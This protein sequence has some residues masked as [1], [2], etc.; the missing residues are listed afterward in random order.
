MG[1]GFWDFLVDLVQPLLNLTIAVLVFIGPV[2]LSWRWA[3]AIRS[4]HRIVK[5][6]LLGGGIAGMVLLM[7]PVY[8][9][10]FDWMFADALMEDWDPLKE[11]M[12]FW[13]FFATVPNLLD[14]IIDALIIGIVR[15]LTE[16]YITTGL[17]AI[18]C[19]VSSGIGARR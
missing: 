11:G 7:N 17:V 15:G 2:Y 14:M 5:G 4:G 6:L 13:R 9:H 19:V 1:Y 8:V 3:V 12:T 10:L 16:Y 18:A